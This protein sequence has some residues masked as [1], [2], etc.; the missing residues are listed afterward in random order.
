MVAWGSSTR[1]STPKLDRH[2]A[3]KFLPPALTRDDEARARFIR[4]AKAAS[5][6]DHPNI[7]TIYEIDSTPDEQLFI[8]MGYYDGETLKSR[9]ERGPVPLDEAIDLSSQVAQGLVKAHAAGIIHRDIKPSNLVVTTDGLVKIV[10]FGLAKLLGVTG[11]TQTGTT[12]GT[13]A[14]MS[15]E[16]VAGE[17]A[18]QQSDVWALGAVLYEMLTGRPPFKGEHQ[19]VVMNAI[20]NR[21]PDR[22]SALRKEIPANVERIAMRALEK[23]REKRYGSA[24]EFLREVT[25]CRALMQSASTPTGH[26]P[27]GYPWLR[28]QV[29]VPAL[30]LLALIAAVAI[31]DPTGG[32]EAT[33]AMDALIPQIEAH[34]NAGEWEAAYALA[35]RAETLAPNDEQLAELWPTFSWLITIPSDPPG[36]SVFRQAFSQE[37]AEWEALG[38]TPV[39][40]IR[41]PFGLSRLRGLWFQWTP[42]SVQ[43]RRGGGT[44]GGH[45]SCTGR[46][47]RSFHS[48]Q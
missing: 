36:A 34:A 47:C 32:G 27:S 24:R 18:D 23:P 10:D 12:L 38:T 30:M 45:G 26:T 48:A 19:W 15:P 9:I 37:D 14:Y 42:W 1:P 4:E 21:P 8:A 33:G 13:V 44:A 41:F 22:P 11:P 31:W 43:V 35:K 7:C 2:V 25:E 6:L 16:Q 5:A 46:R 40:A 29:T 28:P 3:L 20:S 39:K 17:D